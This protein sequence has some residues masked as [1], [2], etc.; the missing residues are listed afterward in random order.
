MVRGVDVE[1]RLMSLGLM[2]LRGPEGCSCVG[3]F[4]RRDMFAVASLVCGVGNGW[5]MCGE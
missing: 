3:G 1:R 5:V 2:F 4:D